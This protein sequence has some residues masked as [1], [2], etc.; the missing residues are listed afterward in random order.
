MLSA[1][2]ALLAT[3]AAR[4]L[5]LLSGLLLPAALLTT[6]AALLIL[7]AGFLLAALA[8]LIILGHEFTPTGG[9]PSLVQRSRLTNCF[10]RALT[11]AA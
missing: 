5:L 2:A 4:L 3:L 1:L 9:F 10:F 8:R 6:V 11:N 7:L